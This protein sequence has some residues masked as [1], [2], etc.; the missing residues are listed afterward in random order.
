[1]NRIHIFLTIFLLLFTQI[2]YAQKIKTDANLVGHVVCCGEHIPFATVLVKGT[3]I[4]V[5]TD[6]TGHYHLINLPEG[7]LTIVVQSLGYKPQEK[8]ITVKA[9]ETKELKFELVRDVLGLEEVVI[10]GDRNATNRVES[11]TIVNTI[12]P[13]L[14]ATTQSV[15]LSEGLN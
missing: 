9:D 14:F 2:N 13:K 6:E 4:G 1:M 10:T 5:T 11:S 8:I 3:T 15:T 12:T 7:T